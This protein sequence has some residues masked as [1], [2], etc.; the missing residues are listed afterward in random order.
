MEHALISMNAGTA[1]TSADTTKYVKT[2]VAATGV[3]VHE[4]IGLRELE[5]HAKTLMN[6]RTGTHASMS[7]ETCLEATNAFVQWDIA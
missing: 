5:D 6:A 3:C 1:C 4:D 7:V 2:L